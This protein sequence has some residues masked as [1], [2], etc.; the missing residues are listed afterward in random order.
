MFTPRQR[1]ALIESLCKWL[2][3]HK[4]DGK[5]RDANGTQNLD[6]IVEHHSDKAITLLT[7]TD[8]CQIVMWPFT[9]LSP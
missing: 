8:I 6:Y 7:D 9:Y 3:R 5:H 4:H 1:K 2:A